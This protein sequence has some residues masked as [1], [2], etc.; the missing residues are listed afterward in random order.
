MKATFALWSVLFLIFL[1]PSSSTIA[2]NRNNCQ[3][4]HTDEGVLKSLHKP[5]AIQA[6]EGE[7]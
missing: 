2:N 5:P 3:G 1:F 7:G 6:E 4:C